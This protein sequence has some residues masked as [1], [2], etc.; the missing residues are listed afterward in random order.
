MKKFICIITMIVCLC[1]SL[2]P[3]YALDPY[4]IEEMNV[5]WTL[6]E[7]GLLYI[8]ETYNMHFYETK[9]ESIS[10]FIPVEK[11]FTVGDDERINTTAAITNVKVL[12]EQPH[13]IEE[14]KDGYTITF[15]YIDNRFDEKET[16]EISYIAKVD[17][18]VY[19]EKE[20]VIYDIGDNR[21]EGRI[22]KLNFELNLPK[23]INEDLIEIT[24][25]YTDTLEYE[26]NDSLIKGSI[27]NVSVATN[28]QIVLE[29]TGGYISGFNYDMV[30]YISIGICYLL[31]FVVIIALRKKGK[32]QE[33]EDIVDISVIHELN[34]LEI[35]FLKKGYSDQRDVV[36]LFMQWAQ[37]GY[38]EIEYLKE[39]RSMVFHKKKELSPLVP[40]YE[41]VL[42]DELFSMNTKVRMKTLGFMF[43]K[44]IKKAQ[45]DMV[46]TFRSKDKKVYLS[47]LE[48]ILLCVMCA[49]PL[50]IVVGLQM[51]MRTMSLLE[52]LVIVVVYSIVIG[53]LCAFMM[54][55]T[56]EKMNHI[57]FSIG[58]C[59]VAVGIYWCSY[60]LY[61][62]IIPYEILLISVILSMILIFTVC[63]IK[64]R[65]D[66]GNE[67]LAKTR[68][69]YSYLIHDDKEYDLLKNSKL[70]EEL[71]PYAYVMKVENEVLQYI[72]ELSWFEVDD[73]EKVT[74]YLYDHIF[75]ITVERKY[76]H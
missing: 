26:V 43:G 29:S 58:L 19:N 3:V 12:N 66:F 22:E 63:Y 47:D 30:N 28:V 35:G 36:A 18:V 50:I 9:L 5:E 55:L 24:S 45:K 73:F 41:K 37:K 46:N 71:L 69:L 44:A 15:G 2:L 23:S 67:I 51:F 16:F 52:V 6:K 40:K 32:E 68:G 76:A 1:T 8:H 4:Y 33:I 53:S 7:N 21:I 42:F 70:K 59:M 31:G 74:S 56:R 48:K 64:I 62:N 65:S 61:G 49:F 10:F 14:K 54:Y 27:E 72:D 60:K 17:P 57:I 39:Q 75:S 34:A 11:R 20:L 13:Y 38:I 25:K